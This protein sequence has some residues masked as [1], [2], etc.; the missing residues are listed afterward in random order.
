MSNTA[1]SYDIVAGEY[2]DPVAHPTCYNFNRLS[3]VYLERWI[4]EPWLNRDVLE[5]GAG[6]SSVAAILHARGYLL[7]G[8]HITDA[9]AKML[10]YSECWET[11]GATLAISDGCSIDREDATVALL[12]ASLGDPYNVPEFWVEVCRVIEPGGAVLFT[13]PSFQ[14]AARFRTDRGSAQRID[15]AEFEL[16]NGHC[17]NVPSFILPLEKQVT[18]MESTGLMVVHFE[19]LGAE[20][21]PPDHL[22][23]KIDVF[24]SDTSSLVWGFRAIRQRR[25]VVHAIRQRWTE[26]LALS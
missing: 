16:L 25:P 12:V 8:L 2:Y 7:N 13:V 20:A 22:S 10:A 15:E 1:P 18:M 17:V 26:G 4:P 11:Y 5:I 9:S 3:R 24:S 19:S 6:N 14:W 23:P 21:L